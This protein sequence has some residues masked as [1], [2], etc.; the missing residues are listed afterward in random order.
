ML[1]LN[2]AHGTSLVMATHEPSLARAR[3]A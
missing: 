3:T 1:E 2:R